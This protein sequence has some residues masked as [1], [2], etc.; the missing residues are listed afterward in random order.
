MKKFIPVLLVIL[1]IIGCTSLKKVEQTEE[2]M[3]T[4]YTITVYDTDTA[5]SQK[6]IDEAFAEI[7]RID[8]VM[9]IYKNTSEVYLLNEKKELTN[10]SDEVVYIIK[11]S[12]GYGDLSDGAFDLTVQPILDLY[13]HTF[14]DLKR[15]PTDEEVKETLRAVSYKDI[16]IEGNDIKLTRPGMKITLGGIAKGYAVDR[17]IEILQKRGIQHVL[18]NAGGNMRA[19]GSKGAEN[20]QIALQNPRN[21]EE[22]ITL[23][24]LDNNAVST[25]GDYE[26]YFNENKTFHHIINPQTGYSATE[27]ISVTIVTGTAMHADA[28]STSV[29]VLGPEKGMELIESLENAEGLLITRD[30][31]IIKSKGFSPDSIS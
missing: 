10:A 29:F 22:Y 5:K 11:K 25:S 12:M 15:P 23:I 18:V 28:L 26:R 24:E 30:K 14:N 4:Y 17:A 31:K 8:N 1:F 3:G 6:A 21:K 7:E 16:K 20:W 2:L 27:L 9:S 13:T 19:I